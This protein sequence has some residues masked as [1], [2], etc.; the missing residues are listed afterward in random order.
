MNRQKNT[1]LRIP[2]VFFMSTFLLFGIM[3]LLQH[4][5][6]PPPP[7]GFDL[8][9]AYVLKDSDGN[10]PGNAMTKNFRRLRLRKSYDVSANPDGQLKQIRGFKGYA[11]IVKAIEDGIIIPSRQ[12]DWLDIVSYTATNFPGG[13]GP[14]AE[15]IRICNLALQGS[16]SP[17]NTIFNDTANLCPTVP[18]PFNVSFALVTSLI[19]IALGSKNRN[20]RNVSN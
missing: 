6:P 9:S 10:T 7:N 3:F 20:I 13:P 4:H 11:I 8:Q 5:P 15:L 14:S 16:G 17:G 1:I 12:G 19:L 18:I 2:K